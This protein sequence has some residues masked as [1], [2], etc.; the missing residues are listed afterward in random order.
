MLCRDC[1]RSQNTDGTQY[2]AER[3][4][5]DK[6]DVIG[7]KHRKNDA[8]NQACSQCRESHG[9]PHTAISC[10]VAV[11]VSGK[12]APA[13]DQARGAGMVRSV[14]D[15]SVSAARRPIQGMGSTT[16]R[17][18]AIEN[19][20]RRGLGSVPKLVLLSVALAVDVVHDDAAAF[21]RH[22]QPLLLLERALGVLVAALP[23]LAHR[24]A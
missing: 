12:G 14:D 20:S 13:L 1:K 22:P 10:A 17:G 23:M 7:N 6:H 19:I 16:L 21:N 5:R 9:T 11:S 15:S 8:S 2:S 24:G 4:Q 3:K 18:C